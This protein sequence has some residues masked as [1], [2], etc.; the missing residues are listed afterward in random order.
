MNKV[1]SSIVRLDFNQTSPIKLLLASET[2]FLDV[3][4][5][6]KQT[7]RSQ[8]HCFFIQ[9]FFFEKN[10]TP[11]YVA[12]RCNGKFNSFPISLLHLL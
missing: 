8:E 2:Q 5:I 4:N 9:H 1:K 12:K 11:L 6:C 3:F 7:R 10:E